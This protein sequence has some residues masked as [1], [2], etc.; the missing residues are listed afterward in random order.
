MLLARCG[1]GAQLPLAPPHPGPDER[2]KADILLIVA[3]PDDDNVIASYLARAIFDQHKRVAVVYTAVGD[4]GANWVGN[5]GGAALGQMRI[6]EA[7]RALDFLGITNVW[8]LGGHD[9]PGQDV[10]WALE[11]WN[12]G[13]FLD[14]VV[15]LVRLTRPEVILTWLPAYSAGENH[16]DH[17]GSSVL[18]NEAFDMAGDPTVFSEQVEP[19]RDTRSIM[20]MTEGLEPWQPKKIYYYSDSFDGFGRLFPSAGGTSPFRK[21]FLT[22]Q[23]PEYSGADISPSRHVSYGH[24]AAESLGFYLT[25]YAHRGDE[26]IAKG[27]L[28]GFERTIRFVFGKSVVPSSTTGDIFEGI[29]PEPAA[30]VR[31]PGYQPQSHSGWSLE[32]GEPW[33]FYQDFWRAHGIEHLARLLPVPEVAIDRGSTLHVALVLRN[34]TANPEEVTLTVA[35]PPGWTEKQGS[36]RYALKANDTYPVPAAVISPATAKLEWQEITWKAEAGGRETG[37]VS[38]RVFLGAGGGIPQ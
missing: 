1:N 16:D 37:K 22:G 35:L 25:Q 20:N 24:L 19:A 11:D 3:H 30:F 14:E 29:G 31:A 7:R 36:A 27:R 32:L 12:H 21:N 26:A 17:Q 33:S 4:G 38:I 18:A 5:E 10:L 13:R 8:F 15:R 2:Y 23:G 28:A 6:L 9:T 34:A